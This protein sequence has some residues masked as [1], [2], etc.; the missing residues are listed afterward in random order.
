MT[1]LELYEELI[2]KLYDASHS[3]YYY[4]D[5]EDWHDETMFGLEKEI[6]E[7]AQKVV[8]LRDEEELNKKGK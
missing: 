4:R 8:E 2:S 5:T 7:L 1:K 3:V 6:D